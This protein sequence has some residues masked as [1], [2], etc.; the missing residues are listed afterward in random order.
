MI[1]LG[2]ENLTSVELLAI[3]ISSGTDRL[4]AVEV[5]K[6]LIQRFERLDRLALASR[7]ELMKVEG[8][9]QAKAL[10]LQAAFQLS[11]NMQREAAQ[12]KFHCFK[13]PADVAKF[14]IPQIGHLQQEVFIGALLDSAGKYIHSETISK[15]TLNASLVHPREVF[16]PAIRFSAASIIL[17]HNH[18]SGQ[19]V[20]STEDL[21]VTQQLI[22]SG[23][24]LEIPVQDHLIVAGDKY[25]SLR[26]D[27]YLFGN[28]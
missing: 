18:P 2:A 1:A 27:G 6:Q 20:A 26:E 7:T 19:L 3:L 21:R 23:K 4:N 13:Q 28:S 25:I 16:K 17:I 10:I 12:Q 9:G 22:E 24:L 14:F 8:I 5:G 11:R 15:G